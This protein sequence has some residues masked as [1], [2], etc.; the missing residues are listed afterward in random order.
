M[1]TWRRAAV[2][3]SATATLI[4]I[5]AG[6]SDAHHSP[7]MFDTSKAVTISGTVVRFERT[8]PHSIIHIEQ[9]TPDGSVEWSIE[10]PAALQ[11]DRR[12]ILAS[13]FRLGA[14]IE[15]CGY[16]LKPGDTGEARRYIVAEVVRMPD[17]SAQLWSPYGQT[18]CREEN[19]YEGLPP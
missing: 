11:L 15:A 9:Q 3:G 5:G 7:A 8:N 10:G 2:A 6:V 14:A 19:H 18:H 16:R 13:A 4:L 17:G 1:K 12:Q